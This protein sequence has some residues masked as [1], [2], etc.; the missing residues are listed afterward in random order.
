MILVPTHPTYCGGA[1]VRLFHTT[2]YFYGPKLTQMHTQTCKLKREIFKNYYNTMICDSL[3]HQCILWDAIVSEVFSRSQKRSRF[4]KP[5]FLKSGSRDHFPLRVSLRTDHILH[6]NSMGVDSDQTRPHVW[7]PSID[8]FGTRRDLT[9]SGRRDSSLSK[10][11]RRVE[12]LYLLL[13]ID[14]IARL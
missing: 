4:L 13:N 3:S 9:K 1:K 12:C 8:A 7:A 11:H 6:S 14:V 10:V 5:K 2:T